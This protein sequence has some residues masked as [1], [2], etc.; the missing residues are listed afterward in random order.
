MASESRGIGRREIGRD[1]FSN[2][3]SDINGIAAQTS[4]MFSDLFGGKNSGNR[5]NTQSQTEQKKEKSSTT[6]GAF[7]RGKIG[8]AEKK[9]II[10]HSSSKQSREDM[11]RIQNTERNNTNNDNQ[12]FLTDVS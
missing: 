5:N 4:N 1:F 6:F 8:L 9:S 3:S 12:A 10:K 2:V 7:R 11:Q